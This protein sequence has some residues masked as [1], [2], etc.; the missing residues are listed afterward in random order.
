MRNMAAGLA[1]GF[2]GSMLFRNSSWAG[3]GLG[4]GGG[5]FG[6]L[7]I[8]LLAGV[9]FLA[10]RWFRRSRSHAATPQ[11]FGAAPFQPSVLPPLPTAAASDDIASVVGMDLTPFKEARVD[12]FFKLQ[13]A[14]MNRELS[15]VRGTLTTEM[16]AILENDISVLKSKGQINRIES[17]AV[18]ESEI[19]EAWQEADQDF[20][21]LHLK[22]SLLDFTVDEKTGA[23]VGGDK[24]TPVKF[25]EYWTFARPRGSYAGSDT[26]KL[27]AIENNA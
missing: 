21:T 4:G 17:I 15:H 23:V 26:W 2:L 11:P 6:F 18:R 13:A 20:A 14:I 25:D 19:I 9:A 22:A 27:T 1:G 16:A 24:N 8:I 7:E 12:D 10:F 5:G 3:N